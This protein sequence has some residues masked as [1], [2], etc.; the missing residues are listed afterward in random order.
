[1]ISLKRIH[2]IKNNIN[3]DDVAVSNTLI[4]L[5]ICIYTYIFMYISL[6]CNCSINSLMMHYSI[7]EFHKKFK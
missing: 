6:K 5:K 4:C 7:Y 2:F 3:I 1:M